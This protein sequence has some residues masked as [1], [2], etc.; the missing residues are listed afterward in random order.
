MAM[1]LFLAGASGVIGQRLVPLLTRAG[2][3]VFGTTRSSTKAEALQSAG[4]QPVV[5]DVFDAARLEEIMIAV[6]PTII[7]HQLTDLPS[8]LDPTQMDEAIKRNALIRSKGTHNLISAARKAGAKRIIAQSIAW[9]YATG[10]EPHVEEDPLD[11]H[12]EGSRAVSVGGV[13]ALEQAVLNSPPLEGVVLRYGHIYGPGTGVSGPIGVAPLHVDAA[14]W[15]AF[16]AIDG[17]RSGVFNIAEPS[18]YVSSSKAM[19]ELGWTANFRLDDSTLPAPP[20]EGRV[21]PCG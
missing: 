5:L 11:L 15:A 16:L 10:A 18:Q 7:I 4:I 2:Y 19:T 6:Q 21:T 12:A 8:A 9:A 3:S 14:A 17:A 13:K 20:Q 1:R